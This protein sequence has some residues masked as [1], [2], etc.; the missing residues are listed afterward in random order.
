MAH[1]SPPHQLLVLK[2]SDFDHVGPHSYEGWQSL[3]P[4]LLGLAG[5]LIVVALA[6]PR[7][8]ASSVSLQ[9]VLVVL[10]LISG[11]LFMACLKGPRDVIAAVFDGHA[12]TVEIIGRGRFA[13]TS[14]HMRYSK[15]AAVHTAIR[16]DANGRKRVV[17]E[18][19]LKSGKR[20]ALPPDIS[21]ANLTL[22]R[23]QL[24]EQARRA[25]PPKRLDARAAL[26][27]RQQRP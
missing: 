17:P 5:P 18:I 8:M 21:R 16:Y 14:W 10:L 11:G 26:A 27:R 25:S 19:E 13:T 9:L 6:F 23:E 3:A 7:L 20:L 12:K 15:L 24:E 2:G 22:L 1:A 4:I